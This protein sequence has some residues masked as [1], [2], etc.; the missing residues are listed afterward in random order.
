MS[1]LL[2]LDVTFGNSPTPWDFAILILAVTIWIL[3]LWLLS[4]AVKILRWSFRRRKGSPDPE[5]GEFLSQIVAV[6]IVFIWCARI[7]LF[8]GIIDTDTGWRLVFFFQPR[9]F[10]PGFLL[11]SLLPSFVALFKFAIAGLE[12][13]R[14]E[15]AKGAPSTGLLAILPRATFAGLNIAASIVTLAKAL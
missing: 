5:S 9:Q 10:A 14:I 2:L 12:T 1:G 8:E 7:F 4:E 13:R 6:G 3:S 15:M 11:G